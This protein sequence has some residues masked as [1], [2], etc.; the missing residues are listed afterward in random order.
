MQMQR[1]IYIVAGPNGAGKT[2][3][4]RTYL[5][6]EE[7]FS[8]FINAD[9]IAAGISP[10][11][12]EAAAIRA[13]RLMLEEI[14]A[15]L[16]QGDSFAFETTLSGRSYAAQI[17][18]WRAAGYLVDLVFLRLRPVRLAISRVKMRVIQGGHHI[19][20][21]V[22]RRRF[23]LDLQNFHELYCPIVSR[24]RLYDNSDDSPRLLDLGENA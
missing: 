18:K 2:T 19:P 15:C 11:H 23:H 9:L 22:V 16:E 8:N 6:N 17:P 10:F 20:A 12:P 3:F 4:A 5:P 21:S 7:H 14:A 1:R 24:W 13:G